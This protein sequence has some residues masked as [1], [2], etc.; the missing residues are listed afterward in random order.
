MTASPGIVSQARFVPSLRQTTITQDAEGSISLSTSSPQAVLHVSGAALSPFPLKPDS[1]Q[2]QPALDPQCSRLKGER[3]RVKEALDEEE[4]KNPTRSPWKNIT[5]APLE[6]Q[7][8]LFPHLV[9]KIAKPFNH[10]LAEEEEEEEE[11][12]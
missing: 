2:L 1:A 9:T 5:L 12:E 10:T 7:S 6:W 11:K 4:A 3:K 8:R